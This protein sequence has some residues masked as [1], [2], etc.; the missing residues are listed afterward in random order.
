MTTYREKPE[1]PEKPQHLI[2]WEKRLQENMSPIESHLLR[3]IE[4]LERQIG[5]LDVTNCRTK[6]VY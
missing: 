5:E 6:R 4:D 2:E 1:P 3:R